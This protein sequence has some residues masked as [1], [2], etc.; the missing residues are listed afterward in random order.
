MRSFLAFAIACGG[1]ASPPPRAATP[2]VERVAIVLAER[3]DQGIHLVGIDEHGDRQFELVRA[4]EGMVR[5][6]DPAIS[7][8]GRWVVFASSRGR[9]FSETSLWIAPVQPDAIATPLTR[10][11]KFLDSHPTWRPDGSGIVFASTRAHGNFDLYELA[12]DRNGR[13]HGEPN[14]LTSADGHEVTPS[15]A[16]DGTIVYASVHALADNSVDSH[17]EARAPDGTIEKLTDGP[18]D[19]SPALSPDG[20]QIA[21]SRPAEHAGMLDGEL[22]VMPRHGDAAALV[23]VRL[24]DESG[25]VWSRDGRFVFATSVLRGS[26]GNAVFSSVVVV[27]LTQHPRV[28]RMLEDRTGAI[29][30][31]SPAIAS[32]ALDARALDGDPE[33]LSEL[34]RITA[35]AA[36]TPAPP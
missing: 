9:D 23:D 15:V 16:R 26:R 12:I 7:P 33:Y 36:A 13:A 28:A 24:T 14:R 3:G 27:D 19:A 10:G 30:R 34:A 25:P 32:I 20:T 1:C 2:V 5:D 17:L 18:G 4:A 11:V 21:F 22:W 6:E 35:K 29:Q 8:D 31:L